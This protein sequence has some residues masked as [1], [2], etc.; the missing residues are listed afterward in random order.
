MH[1]LPAK[2][3]DNVIGTIKLIYVNMLLAVHF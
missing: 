2:F 3:T 1:I